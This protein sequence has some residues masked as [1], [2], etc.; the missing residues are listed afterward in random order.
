MN[1]K[2]SMRKNKRYKKFRKE[3][4]FKEKVYKVVKKIPKGKTM[5]YKEVAEVAGFPKAWRAVG[6]VLN[7]NRNPKIPCHR[8]IKS[9]GTPGGYY[10]GTKKKIVLL[11]KEGAL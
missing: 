11:K 6:N 1:C 8:V 9:N 7:K 5:S 2:K 4:S 10:L 3:K